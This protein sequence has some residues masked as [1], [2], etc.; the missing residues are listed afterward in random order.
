MEDIGEP[1][2]PMV[3]TPIAES[4]VM[5]DCALPPIAVGVGRGPERPDLVLIWTCA[6]HRNAVASALASR[7]VD[8]ESYLY[9]I[10][11]TCA[12][13]ERHGTPCGAAA[14]YVA[15]D[16]DAETADAICARHMVRRVGGPH[17]A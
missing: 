8:P 11:A 5:D 3:I 7:S 12:V 17:R 6:E 4:C 9:A 10:G 16:V 1:L 2:D 14:D 13:V 15:V